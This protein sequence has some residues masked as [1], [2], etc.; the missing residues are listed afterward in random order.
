[1]RK[2]STYKISIPSTKTCKY[3]LKVLQ[4]ETNVMV[5]YKMCTQHT[6]KRQ[7]MQWLDSEIS[8]CANLII[9]NETQR[10]A[11][12][13]LISGYL[14]T[15]EN[16]FTTALIEMIVSQKNVLTYQRIALCQRRGCGH[17]CSQCHTFLVRSAHKRR[18]SRDRKL[19]YNVQIK[20]FTL[21]NVHSVIEYN[22]KLNHSKNLH[23]L[24]KT[25]TVTSIAKQI[26]YW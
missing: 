10:M 11:F 22:F 5:N 16:K 23:K 4:C 12:P 15:C 24:L 3:R 19:L 8:S 13:C 20:V 14:N 18:H 6:K 1:M 7:C 25:A 26:K 9:A 17:I 2:F 21:V